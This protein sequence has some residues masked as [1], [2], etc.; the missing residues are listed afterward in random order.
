[1][2]S[3]RMSYNETLVV[4]YYRRL[5][6]IGLFRYEKLLIDRYF[7]RGGKTLDIGC[8]AGRVTLQ[9]HEMGYPVIG[10]DYAEKMIMTA[11]A[12]NDEIDYRI[13]DILLAPF[14]DG[15]FDNIIFSFNGLMLIDSY[16]KRLMA[17]REIYRMLKEH[18]R[19]IF[20]TP[21]LDNK[22]GTPYWKKKATTLRIDVHNMT[23]EQQLKL[24]DE[25]LEDRDSKFFLHIPFLSEIKNLLDESGMRELFSARRLDYSGVEEQEEELDDNYLWVMECKK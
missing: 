18:G 17:M 2:H 5:A 9:L 20:T 25:W 24:G 7:L 23:W 10:M 4:D 3:N 6:S 12:L 16:S 13:G 21:F 15:E 14:S 1:M 19:L 11:K 8:G 22:Q